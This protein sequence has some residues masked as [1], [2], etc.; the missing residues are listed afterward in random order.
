MKILYTILITTIIIITLIITWFY[1]YLRVNTKDVSNKLPFREVIGKELILDIDIFLLRNN[2]S[3][4]HKVTS[5]VVD[6]EGDI[7][8]IDEGNM[9]VEVVTKG[10]PLSINKAIIQSHGESGTYGLI[11]GVLHTKQYDIPFKQRWGT[12]SPYILDDSEPTDNTNTL[13]F[14]FNKPIWVSETEHKITK[15]YFLPEL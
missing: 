4:F 2:T 8:T 9:I 6:N 1:F 3:N 10:T 15:T 7:G 13:Y 12:L 5:T 11:T 14:T